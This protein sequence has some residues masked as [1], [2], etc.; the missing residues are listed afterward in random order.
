MVVT[1]SGI[2]SQPSLIFNP[3]PTC[4][5]DLNLDNVVD[6][7]DLA[8]LLSAWGTSGST[9]TGG[10]DLDGSGTVDGSDLGILLSAWGAC[11]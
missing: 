4:I 3:K 2:A 11:P 10:G 7:A 1:A 9:A 6:G 8:I 5:A